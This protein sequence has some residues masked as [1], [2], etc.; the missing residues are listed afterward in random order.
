MV[1]EAACRV[2][3]LVAGNAEIQQGTID[4]RDVKLR[5]DTRCLAEVCLYHLGGQALEPFGGD[6]HRIRVL[7]ERPVVRRLAIWVLCPAPPA[8]PSR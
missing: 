2:V 8:V 7:V 6:C 5:K 4:R 3:Q 1:G